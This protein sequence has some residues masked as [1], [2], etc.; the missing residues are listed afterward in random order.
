M[1]KIYNLGIV[2]CNMHS[3]EKCDRSFLTWLEMGYFRWFWL[4]GWWKKRYLICLLPSVSKTTQKEKDASWCADT[5]WIKNVQK[6][7]LSFEK[8]RRSF[9]HFTLIEALG[10]VSS[11][12]IMIL[13]V[14]GVD[15]GVNN[16]MLSALER[17]RCSFVLLLWTVNEMQC[18]RWMWANKHR[19]SETPTTRSDSDQTG[20]RQSL[21]QSV[22][23]TCQTGSMSKTG[24]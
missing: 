21:W 11:N 16:I 10:T 15:T 14:T 17:S 4:I 18:V 24:L 19:Q 12:R 20:R 7:V 8:G 6:S 2:E 22:P 5:K 23:K 3:F 1:F 13:L 9:Q